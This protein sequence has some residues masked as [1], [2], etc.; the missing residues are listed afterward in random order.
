MCLWCFIYGL[1]SQISIW[2]ASYLRRLELQMKS[3]GF[4]AFDLLQR[5][6]TSSPY[7]SCNYTT[8]A[9]CMMVIWNEW[10]MDKSLSSSRSFRPIIC[11][12]CNT[13]SQITDIW[14][15]K[16][17]LTHFHLTTGA[18]WHTWL[19]W[20]AVQQL[21]RFY[22]TPD[23]PSNVWNDECTEERRKYKNYTVE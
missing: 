12:H 3:R 22:I 20:S 8:H 9:G 7:P 23:V 1:F 18:L 17:E 2:H 21:P 6:F 4:Q 16:D 11:T 19:I 15:L 14:S 10:Y 13:E 5:V